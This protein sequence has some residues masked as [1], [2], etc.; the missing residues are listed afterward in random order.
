L[1]SIEGRSLRGAPA[2]V[3]G[4]GK[5]EPS[6]ERKIGRMLGAQNAANALR[7]QDEL[8]LRGNGFGC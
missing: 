7:L 6:R 5:A 4:N 3:H 1:R 8:Y 2:L